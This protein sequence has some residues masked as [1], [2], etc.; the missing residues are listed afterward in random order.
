MELDG[1][2]LDIMSLF[3]KIIH[4]QLHVGAIFF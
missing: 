2:F 4:R 3:L 1:V